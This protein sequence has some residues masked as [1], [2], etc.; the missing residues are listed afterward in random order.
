MSSPN[1]HLSLTEVSKIKQIYQQ[2]FKQVSNLNNQKL[3]KLHQKLD[4]ILSDT[5]RLAGTW[6]VYA[7]TSSHSSLTLRLPH[8]RRDINL[9]YDYVLGL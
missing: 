1:H 9:F 8:P 3:Q 2:Q 7:A 4:L 6:P 5:K